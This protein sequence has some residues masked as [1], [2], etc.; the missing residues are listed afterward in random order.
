MRNWIWQLLLPYLC[1]QSRKL[2]FSWM[3]FKL[4]NA[5][6]V[7]HVNCFPLWMQ[8]DEKTDTAK[9]FKFDV[10]N[11]PGL[12]GIQFKSCL[13]LINKNGHNLFMFSCTAPSDS[14]A[15]IQ[16][17]QIL[18]TF[19]IHYNLPNSC[20]HAKLVQ[21]AHHLLT[22]FL[23]TCNFFQSYKI[24]SNLPSQSYSMHHSSFSMV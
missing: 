20:Q 9:I 19:Q 2:K 21:V 1:Q 8:P 16:H 10:Q 4:V 24:L 7:P 3:W 17:A 12:V 13:K 14:L 6:S 23:T 5:L 22:R 15:K 18:L 11:P